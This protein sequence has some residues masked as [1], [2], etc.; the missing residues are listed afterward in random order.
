ML[1][2]M[3]IRLDADPGSLRMARKLAATAALTAG[4]TR[5]DALE[6]EIALGEALANA[7][8]HAYG[9]DPRGRIVVHFELADGGLR[10]TVRDGGRTLQAIPPIP[11]E[12]RPEDEAGRGLYIMSKLM[13]TVEVIHPDRRGR[14]TAIRMTKRLPA[15]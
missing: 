9:G 3:D 6:L 12:V 14:G 2:E 8:L 13:D 1:W 7:F 5:A 10:V 4:A 15:H 11:H